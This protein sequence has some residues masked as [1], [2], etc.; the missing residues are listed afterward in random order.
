MQVVSAT[1]E[2]D[3]A[4]KGF[5]ITFTIEEGPIYHFGNV[6]VQSNVRAVDLQS[7]KPILLTYP[8]DIYNGELV[9]KSVENLTVEVS[10]EAIHSLPCGRAAIAIPNANH[11]PFLRRR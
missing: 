6:E 2:Y 5:T 8:G 10:G 1:S 7:L 4:K 11:R 3:P 9:E